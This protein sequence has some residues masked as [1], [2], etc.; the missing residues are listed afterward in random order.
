G[1]SSH[2]WFCG[3]DDGVVSDGAATVEQ[4]G[5]QS[6]RDV[7]VPTWHAVVLVRRVI[8]PKTVPWGTRAEPKSLAADTLVLYSVLCR[9]LCHRTCN[10]D[11]FEILDHHPTHHRRLRGAERPLLHLLRACRVGAGGGQT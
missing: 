2:L 10:A 5:R 9:G 4:S 7:G 6:R 8:C 1:A 11:G 3:P